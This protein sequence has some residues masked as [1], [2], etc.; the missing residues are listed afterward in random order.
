MAFRL[1]CDRTYGIA[2]TLP[3]SVDFG[4]GIF[5]H[6]TQL[7]EIFFYIYLLFLINLRCLYQYRSGDL[8]KFYLI[9][10][11]IFRFFIDFTKTRFS[12]F[13]WFECNSNCLW[14]GYP[15]LFA[16]YSAG[17]LYSSPQIK[18]N[19]YLKNF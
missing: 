10:Y 3:W 5:L 4:D 8:F 15:I 9:S 13:I 17:V 6:P 12:S 7:Y 2:T 1:L 18:V 14:I 19:F 11:V 16:Q